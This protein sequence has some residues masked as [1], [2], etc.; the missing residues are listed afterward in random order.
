M[1]LLGLLEELK[2]IEGRLYVGIA[3]HCFLDQVFG[4]Q[5]QERNCNANKRLFQ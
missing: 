2:S 5:T 4:N 1:N 3:F